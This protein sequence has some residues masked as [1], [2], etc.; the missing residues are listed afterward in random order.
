MVES[1]EIASN[2]KKESRRR[3]AEVHKK[4]AERLLDTYHDVTAVD[5]GYKM[6]EGI[7]RSDG[8]FC[9]LVW[10]RKKLPEYQV[11]PDQLLPKK[12]DGVDVDVLEGE[13]VFS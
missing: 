12:I 5:I 9:L 4:H 7:E 1:T 11:A 3:A 8:E 2:H 10:V 6:K 13:V